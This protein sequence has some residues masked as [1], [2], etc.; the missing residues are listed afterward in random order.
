MGVGSALSG[1]MG[2]VGQG[3][4]GAASRMATPPSGQTSQQGGQEIGKG[5]G[6]QVDREQAITTLMGS[7]NMSREQAEKTADQLGLTGQGTEQMKEQAKQAAA[8]T[9]KYGAAAA[10]WFVITSLLSLGAAVWGGQVGFKNRNY[11]Y[12]AART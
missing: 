2:I 10:W 11:E 1:L 5:G 6:G 9:A 8:T 7:T 12:K 4:Q 3:A